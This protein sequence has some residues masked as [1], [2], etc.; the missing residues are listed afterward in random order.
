VKIREL[1]RDELDL[2]WSIDRSEVIDHIYYHRNGALVLVPEHFD[3]QGWPQGEAESFMPL[4]VDCYDRGGTFWGAF[5]C[6]RLVGAAVLESEFIGS[7]RDQLQ[8]VFLHVSRSFRRSGL[9][10]TLFGMA[11]EKA[12]SLGARRLYISATPSHNTITFYLT[13]GCVVTQEVDA[14]LFELEPEDIHL[15]YTIP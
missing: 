10:R 8:L 6:T 15:E 1:A 12:R 7:E 3:M 14:R 13:L 11:V 2:L 9:G 5:D 4:L